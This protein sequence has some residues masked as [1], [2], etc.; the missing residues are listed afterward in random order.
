M[1]W[2]SFPDL[3]SGPAE[4]MFRLP[5]SSGQTVALE[6]YRQREGLALLFLP[7][8]DETRWLGALETLAAAREAL[9][10]RDAAPLAVLPTTPGVAAAS[11]RQLTRPLLLLA[12]ADGRTRGRYLALAPEIPPATAFLFLLD[13]W[14]APLAAGTLDD[15]W[16]DEALAWFDLALARCPE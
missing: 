4:V 3:N 5:A 12:D 10:Q 14:G 6:H 7:D 1:T 13:R 9:Q 11:A 15:D 16:I 2:V 8:D